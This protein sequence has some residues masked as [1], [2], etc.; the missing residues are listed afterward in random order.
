MKQKH[1]ELIINTSIIFLAKA[2]T[3]LI[4]FLML[5]LYTSVLPTEDYGLVDLITTYSALAIPLIGFQLEMGVFRYLVDNRNNEKNKTVL[6]TNSLITIFA[7]LLFFTAIYLAIASIINLPYLWL[8]LASTTAMLASNYFL[9]VARGL[10]D[11]IGY[12]IGSIITGISTVAINL[13]LLLVLHMGVS[14]ILIATTIANIFC[15]IFLVFR[16]KIPKYIN[17][18]AYSK[19]EVAKLLK[20]SAPLVSN[21]LI[22]WVINVSDR[23]IISIFMNMA[24]NGIYAVSNKFSNIISSIYGVFNLS[25]TESASLHINDDDRDEFFSNTFN[26]TIKTFTCMSLLMLAFMPIIF[27]IMVGEG[28][29]EACLYIPVLAIGMIFNIVVSFMGAIY[30]AKKKTKEVAITSFWSGVLNIAINVALIK[31]I[32]IWAAALSTLLA[33]AIMAVYRYFDV[34]KYVKLKLNK[35]LALLLIALTGACVAFYYI[36]NVATI[37]ANIV[38]VTSISIYINR[39]TIKTLVKSV[40]MKLLS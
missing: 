14:G 35:K 26:T 37:M 8:I 6:I 38:L 28:Y 19:K 32:G 34:Q 7:S 22:W 36:N 2:C 11:N 12:S 21:S 9:Q 33:F 31:V 20:Y 16:E 17:L 23:T 25:W 13:I 5:P 29:D 24:A 40:K 27:K 3:Q 18:S 4:S 10:G 15:V 39:G 1:K 30:I